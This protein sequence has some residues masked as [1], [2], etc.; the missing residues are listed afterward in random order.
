MHESPGFR[1]AMADDALRPDPV[2]VAIYVGELSQQLETL[3]AEAGHVGLAAYLKA[4]VWEARTL[5]SDDPRTFRK[6]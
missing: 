3:A 1:S 2:D 4:A 6:P 5:G